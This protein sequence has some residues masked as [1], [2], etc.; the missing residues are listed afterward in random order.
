MGVAIESAESIVNRNQR[1]RDGKIGRLRLQWP[2]VHASDN[3][4]EVNLVTGA[5]CQLCL[6][7]TNEDPHA[8]CLVLQPSASASFS[9]CTA[10]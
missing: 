6:F 5:A 4:R 10:P 8:H 3:D 2:V 9:L 7:K 1:A